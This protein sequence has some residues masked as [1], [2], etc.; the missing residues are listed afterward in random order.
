MNPVN[1]IRAA[2]VLCMIACGDVTISAPTNP[3]CQAL[4]RQG[5]VCVAGVCVDAPVGDAGPGQTA[6]GGAV[7]PPIERVPVDAGV[8]TP[9]GDGTTAESAAASCQDLLAAK[10]ETA[11][12]VFWIDPDG[13]DGRIE[14]MQ[15]F[16]GMEYDD[17]GWTQV[18]RLEYGDRVWDAWSNSEGDI[19]GRGSWG[20][21]LNWFS[22]DEDGRDLEIL[23][24]ATGTSETGY[25]L[26]PSYS[27][28]PSAAW[29]PGVDV[30]QQI[31]DGF[32]FRT[33][34][35][36]FQRCEAQIW[37]RNQLWSWAISRGED[38]CAGWSGGGGFV[39][40]GSRR[41]A[42]R[43]YSLWGLNAFGA[44]NQGARFEAVELFVRRR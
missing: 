16:C 19:G 5:E 13:A 44:G 42:D 21:A 25:Y 8:I 9:G 34:G 35:Q 18:A 24:G 12:D 39:I 14:P 27:D 2:V 29:Q 30:E 23:I 15:L 40:Y 28:V 10:P 6:D 36:D 32:D 22:N 4:C 37:R 33:P 1:C 43:A 7:V 11:S 3:D 31:G 17:G 38:G 26:G 20:V 41:G